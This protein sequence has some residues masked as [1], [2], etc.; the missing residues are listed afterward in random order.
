MIAS[1]PLATDPKPGVYTP[2]LTAYISNVEI[3]QLGLDKVHSDYGG[4]PMRLQ[5]GSR[6]ENGAQ[7]IIDSSR[8]NRTI[9]ELSFAFYVNPNSSAMRALANFA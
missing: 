7:P 1:M 8:V 9:A 3:Y 4:I 6:L 2:F 5:P